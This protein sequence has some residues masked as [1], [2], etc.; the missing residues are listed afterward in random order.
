MR[1]SVFGL[2]YVGA[3]SGACLAKSGHQVT[4]VD[5]SQA[6]VDIINNGECPI[7]EPGLPELIREVTGNGSFSATIDAA[8]AINN[9]DITMIAVGTPS[10]DSGNVNLNAVKS[11]LADL[12]DLLAGKQDYHVVVIRSTVPP[13][14]TDSL[15]NVTPEIAAA[16]A[17]DR[18]GFV[19]NPE[20]LRE[21]SSIDDFLYPSVTIVGENSARAGQV[22]QMNVRSMTAA[23]GRIE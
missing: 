12:S 2:G 16:V 8:H 6:K 5:V 3:V 13:G 10:D 15:I 20:F 1:I 7:V 22:T 18:I 9:S 23:L 11:C 19:M 17:E 21:G 4:G 14:T